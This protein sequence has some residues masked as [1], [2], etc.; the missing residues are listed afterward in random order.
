MAVPGAD[1][2]T[3]EGKKNEGKGGR[4]GERGGQKAAKRK[5]KVRISARDMLVHK[6]QP[7]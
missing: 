7:V 2:S 1:T 4:R 5:E 6:L 3:S